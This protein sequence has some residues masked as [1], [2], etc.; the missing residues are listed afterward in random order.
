[1]WQRPE[2]PLVLASQSSTRRALLAS[3]GL[4]FTVHPACI[5]E[6]AVKDSARAEGLSASEAA[7]LLAELKARQISRLKPDA[8]VIGADQILLSAGV[9]Y[10]KP[11]NA[12]AARL[13]LQTL[14]G[15]EHTLAS[16]TVCCRAGQPVWHHLAEPRLTMRRFSDAFLDA[17]LA[18]A[19]TSVTT[20]VGAYQLESRGIHL[21]SSLEGAHED[22]LGLPLLPLLEYLRQCGLLLS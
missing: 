15:N 14:R 8:L 16:A 1:M 7:V 10:D 22:I 20:T 5:D 9:W 3:A 6:P 21:F 2:P 13:Q 17:Y 19:G 4:T 18:E 12:A 11:A